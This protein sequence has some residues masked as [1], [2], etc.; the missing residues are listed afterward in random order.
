M[1]AAMVMHHLGRAPALVGNVNVGKRYLT[2]G[3]KLDVEAL[4]AKRIVA[5][6]SN[7][8]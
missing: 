5:K 3:G 8:R 7:K 1:A 6:H 2:S 4:L